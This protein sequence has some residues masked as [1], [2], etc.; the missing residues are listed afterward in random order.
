M[1]NN[2]GHN[3]AADFTIEFPER[4]TPPPEKRKHIYEDKQSWCNVVL[5]IGTK[6]NEHDISY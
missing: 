3:T 2:E 4:C 1:C 6:A 5:K